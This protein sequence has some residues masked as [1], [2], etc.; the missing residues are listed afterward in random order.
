MSISTS[1]ELSNILRRKRGR[2]I[3]LWIFAR[4]KVGELKINTTLRGGRN[5]YEQGIM[6]PK[7]DQRRI[8]KKRES[9]D[10]RVKNDGP[11][12]HASKIYNLTFKDSVEKFSSTLTESR[13]MST[14]MN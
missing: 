9:R 4:S 3:T 8:M 7:R 5:T 11:I 6:L 2:G 14:I 13:M 1:N 12:N 10:N